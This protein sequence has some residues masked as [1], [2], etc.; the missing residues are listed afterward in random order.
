MTPRERPVPATYARKI[1]R[2]ERSNVALREA[3][4]EL[5]RRL[6]L[7]ERAAY[8][9]RTRLDARYDDRCLECGAPE[10]Q[11]CRSPSNAPLPKP[12]HVRGRTQHCGRKTCAACAE[13]FTDHREASQ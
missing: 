10:G 3:N 11:V 1:A 4:A 12:H 13:N 2:L 8:G 7:K 9:T 6:G 5:R